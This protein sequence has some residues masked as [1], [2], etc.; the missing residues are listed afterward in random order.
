M[1][2]DSFAI[3]IIETPQDEYINKTWLVQKLNEAV[4]EIKEKVPDQPDYAV[5]V[6]TLAQT[7]NKIQP[8]DVVEV[9]RCKDCKYCISAIA[10]DAEYELCIVDNDVFPVSVQK[11]HFCSRG[12]KEDKYT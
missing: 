9:V 6:E 2:E 12:A 8:A 4:T 1:K 3:G 10:D 7:I 5:I 11:Q